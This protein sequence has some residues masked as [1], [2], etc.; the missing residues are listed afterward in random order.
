MLKVQESREGTIEYANSDRKPS[1]AEEK[2]IWAPNRADII[3]NVPRCSIIE[4]ATARR[5]FW[6]ERRINRKC[7]VERSRSKF[8]VEG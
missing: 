7:R 6:K 4:A 3:E 8:K 5:Y 2:S 1:F